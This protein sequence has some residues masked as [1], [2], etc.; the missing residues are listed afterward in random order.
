[1]NWNI[2]KA[3]LATTDLAFVTRAEFERYETVCDEDSDL[4][5]VLQVGT[6]GCHI[7]CNHDMRKFTMT[8]D[9]SIYT[10]NTVTIDEAIN[11]LK[12]WMKQEGLQDELRKDCM[13]LAK[14]IATV[15]VENKYWPD[16]I[17]EM[18]ENG[19]EVMRQ[20]AHDDYENYFDITFDALLNLKKKIQS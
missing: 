12:D 13:D 16:T 3:T 10:D 20:E 8:I 5:H 2:S 6:D 11:L 1:M 18:D 14:E 4:T 9:R 15:M 19:E 17:H 7:Q